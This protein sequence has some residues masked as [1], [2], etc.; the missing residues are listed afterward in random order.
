MS[1]FAII[2]LLSC[3]TVHVFPDENAVDPTL[4]NVLTTV[5]VTVSEMSTDDYPITI[6]SDKSLRLIVEAFKYDDAE[7]VIERKELV[8]PEGSSLDDTFS[9][10]MDLSATRYTLVAWLTYTDANHNYDD[11]YYESSNGLRNISLITPAEGNTDHKDCYYGNTEVNLL[12]YAGQWNVDIE[13]PIVV[14]RPIAKYYL[15]AN[16]VSQFLTKSASTKSVSYSDIEKYTAEILYEG[17]IPNGLNAYTGELNDA[18]TGLSYTS[19]LVV[20]NDEKVAVAMDYALSKNLSNK[21]DDDGTTLSVTV[22]I[23]DDQG[24]L[25]NEQGEVQI[26]TQRGQLTIVE[27]DFFTRSVASGVIVDQNFDGSYDIYLDDDGNV[28]E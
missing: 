1:L 7:T 15:V 6:D 14:E 24:E 20:I 11:V 13:I 25:V 19:S 28:I 21:S 18:T 5:S 8:L 26:F 12:S 2:A 22:K 10:E 23:Y 4:V 9:V 17:F 16:D 3:D 27:S